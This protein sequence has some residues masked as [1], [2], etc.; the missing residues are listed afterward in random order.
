VQRGEERIVVLGRVINAH[1]RSEDH[2]HK[3]CLSLISGMQEMITKLYARELIIAGP[4]KA[5][6]TRWP[7]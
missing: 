3:A 7:A 6:T 2:L 4:E 1:D 5:E